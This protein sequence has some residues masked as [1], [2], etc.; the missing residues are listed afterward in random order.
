MIEFFLDKPLSIWTGEPNRY[1]SS[2]PVES[3]PDFDALSGA[4][5]TTFKRRGIS[6]TSEKQYVGSLRLYNYDFDVRMN[7]QPKP[8]TLEVCITANPALDCSN[9]IRD[10]NHVLPL[11]QP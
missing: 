8:S 9:L 6:C 10:I 3:C 2:V 11:L 4:L 5:Q 7:Y 1:H